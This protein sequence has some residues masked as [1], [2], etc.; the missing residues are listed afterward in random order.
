MK[1]GVVLGVVAA[2]LVHA[3]FLLFG[4]LLFPKATESGASTHTVDL[5]SELESEKK[6]EE[7]PEDEPAE[8]MDEIA[9]ED[10][11]P[12]DTAEILKNLESAP[13]NDDAPALEAA[14][15][16]AIEAA[17]SGVTSGGDFAS[18][19]DFASGGRI[20]GTG[21]ASGEAQ[22]VDEIFSLAELDQEPRVIVQESPAIPS[23]MRGRK[24]EG[25]VTVIFVVD[26]SG[27]VANPRAE[28]SSHAA[29]EPN[30]LSA[31]RKWKFE[32]GLRA[33]KRVSSKMR[34]SIR[35][36]AS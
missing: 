5:L 17:L 20:G 27:K 22:K 25:V 31:V 35:F 16:S 7:Q 11:T 13:A 2:F 30:A 32:P 34:V 6:E 26:E 12:P 33:G 18:A 4:G 8:P 24:L 36:P 21:T 1:L 19:L 14:S 3:F 29:F 9:T 23:E 28:K 10:E 15:L